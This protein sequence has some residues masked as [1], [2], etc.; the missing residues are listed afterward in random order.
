MTNTT[1]TH[2]LA[3]ARW[4]ALLLLLLPAGHAVAQAPLKVPDREIV[5]VWLLKTLR[6]DGEDREY[7]SA[8]YTQVKIY[9]ANGEYACAEITRTDKGLCTIFPHEYGTYTLKNG[10]Y[11]EMGR[12]AV[13]I[14]WTSRTTFGGRW[15]NTIVSWQKAANF[16]EALRQHILEKCKAARQSPE[17]MQ[18]A[19][20]QHIFHL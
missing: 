14:G 13:N 20:R 5:G 19:M 11:S 12:D 3:A 17:N 10:R 18:A 4:L 1:P 2:A 7:V 15:K 6:F 8:N 16:P 9:G